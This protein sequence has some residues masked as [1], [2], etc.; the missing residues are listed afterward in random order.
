MGQTV[1]FCEDLASKTLKKT[2]HGYP[3][4]MAAPSTLSQFLNW[5]GH[6]NQGLSRPAVINTWAVM[7]SNLHVCT[8]LAFAAFVAKTRY[9]D[10]PV[11]NMRI[12]CIYRQVHA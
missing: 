5:H 8:V 4:E 2:Q 1:D 9:L 12:S 3:I 10:Q 6:C 11:D 7:H